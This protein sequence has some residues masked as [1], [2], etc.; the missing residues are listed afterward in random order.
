MHLHHKISTKKKEYATKFA[1]SIQKGT[2][3]C[4]KI[5]KRKISKKRKLR[6]KSV[7]KSAEKQQNDPAKQ[8]SK[9]HKNHL[10]KKSA[11][12]L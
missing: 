3:T 9:P 5:C 2:A 12:N 1:I 6:V 8:T 10:S 11:K 7:K 4:K